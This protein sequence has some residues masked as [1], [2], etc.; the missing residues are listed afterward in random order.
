MPLI[1]IQLSAPVAAEKKKELI[2][3]CSRILAEV[4]GK[5]ER[6]VMA[7]LEA[8]DFLVAGA[9]GPAAFLDVRG[10]GGLT[11]PVNARLSRQL[12]DLLKKDLGIAPERIYLNFTDVPATNWGWNGE[13][14]G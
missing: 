8:G 7:V 2:A 12:C 14:F 13:T 5:P 3:D 10:I 9:P 1:K 6:Y 4:T 11:K